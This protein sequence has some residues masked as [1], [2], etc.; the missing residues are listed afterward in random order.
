MDS[1]FE[2][3]DDNELVQSVIAMDDS[4]SEDEK[5]AAVEETSKIISHGEAETMLSKCIDWFEVQ[6]EANVTQLLLLRKIHSSGRIKT[7]EN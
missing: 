4:V 7:K 5:E 2:I 3:L 6:E 1:G